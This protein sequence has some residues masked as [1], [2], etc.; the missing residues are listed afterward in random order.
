[1]MSSL[2]A[3]AI[4]IIAG[5]VVAACFVAFVKLRRTKAQPSAD[6]LELPVLDCSLLEQGPEGVAR[7]SAELN[8]AL[9]SV[10]F[11]FLTK[12]GVDQTLIDAIFSQTANFAT[13]LFVSTS[14]ASQQ[15]AYSLSELL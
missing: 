15:E 10:G 1:M 7:F 14:R 6:K 12:H 5:G 9:E 3:T 2:R 13:T 8:A 11:F 4:P